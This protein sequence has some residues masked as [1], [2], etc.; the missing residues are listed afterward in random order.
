MGAKINGLCAAVRGEARAW[1]SRVGMR[2]GASAWKRKALVQGQSHIAV[3]LGAFLYP[4]TG[5]VAARV[6]SA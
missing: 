4:C 3:T 2:P 5:G 1:W 6:L